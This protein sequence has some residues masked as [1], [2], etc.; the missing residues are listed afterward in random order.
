MVAKMILDTNNEKLINGLF[1]H[2]SLFKQLDETTL[3]SFM[4]NGLTHKLITK[5]NHLEKKN[6]DVWKDLEKIILIL[7]EK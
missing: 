3:Q 1:N 2:M 7:I 4:D 6:Y 5:M